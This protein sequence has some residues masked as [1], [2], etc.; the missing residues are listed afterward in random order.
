MSAWRTAAAGAASATA[1]PP[2]TPASIRAAG[3]TAPG[4]QLPAAWSAPWPSQPPPSPPSS[5]GAAASASARGRPPSL[6]EPDKSLEDGRQPP[7]PVRPQSLPP[8]PAA[9]LPR[10]SLASAAPAAHH[11]DSSG[12]PLVSMEPYSTAASTAD[13]GLTGSSLPMPGTPAVDSLGAGLNKSGGGGAPTPV[14]SGGTPVSERRR[15][16]KQQQLLD[17]LRKWEVRWSAIALGDFIGKG[18]FG[19]VSSERCLSAPRTPRRL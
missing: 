8:P 14:S 15:F 2:A 5:S 1:T 17:D 16:S 4:A 13:R 19:K 12:P 11:L 3:T 9:P 6:S 10:S 7:V 18:S